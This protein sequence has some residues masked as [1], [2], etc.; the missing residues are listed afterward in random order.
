MSLSL[1]VVHD[2]E[3]LEEQRDAWASLLARSATNHPTLTP[4]W[5]L[6]WWS[7]FG[8]QAGRS[9]KVGLFHAQDRLVGIAP[10][11]ARRFWYRPAIPFRRIEFLGSGECEA[12]EICSDYL[13][14]IVERGFENAIARALLRAVVWGDFGGCDE[15]VLPAMDASTGLPERLAAQFAERGFETWTGEASVCPY[16]PL[17]DSWEQYLAALSGSRRYFIRRSIRDLERFASGE[18]QVERVTQAA[19]LARGIQILR[20]LHDERWA[21]EG[22]SGAFA[23]ADFSRFHNAV[24]PKLFETDSLDL[25]WLSVRGEPLAVLYNIVHGGRLYFYQSGRSL[26]VPKGLRPGIVLHAHAIQ[27][28]IE[29]GLVEY[30]FLA[31]SSRYKL[32]LALATRPLVTFRAARPSVLEAARRLSESGLDRARIWKRSIES[33]TAQASSHAA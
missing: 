6:T 32:E 19:D 11:L 15:I 3:R 12:D 28:A 8:S 22:R 9:L 24:I 17:P 20:D 33:L 7:V 25:C 27:R 16:I 1:T 31:G 14:I 30:D 23:S 29:R 4:S 5:L 2:L 26:V 10:F 21:A 18:Y 13:S